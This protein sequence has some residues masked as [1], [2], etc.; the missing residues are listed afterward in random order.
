MLHFAQVACIFVS[1]LDQISAKNEK[2]L[3]SLEVDAFP[4]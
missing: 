2:G 3:E 4:P 1:D